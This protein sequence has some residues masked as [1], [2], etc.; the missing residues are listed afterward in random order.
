MLRRHDYG[1]LS[2]RRTTPYGTGVVPRAGTRTS[3]LVGIECEGSGSMVLSHNDP[4][5]WR[6]IYGQTV[7]V[8]ADRAAVAR[9]A[10]CA[11]SCRSPGAA[12]R[13]QF[14]TA[15]AACRAAAPATAV[16]ARLPP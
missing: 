8:N 5:L 10:C 15:A 11:G 9:A 4:S 14:R 6:S 3:P 13:G 2:F 1:R 7:A 16:R 12:D